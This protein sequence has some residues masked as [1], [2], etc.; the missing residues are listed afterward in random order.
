MSLPTL[1]GVIK[2]VKA[3]IESSIVVAVILLI[4]EVVYRLE[5]RWKKK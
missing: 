4:G 5:E 1:N 2:A 3:L